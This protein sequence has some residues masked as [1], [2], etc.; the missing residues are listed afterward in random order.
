[1]HRL[2]I[3]VIG[4]FI[5]CTIDPETTSRFDYPPS[6]TA[7]ADT[8]VSINDTVRLHASGS[9]RNG[10]IAEYEWSFDGGKQWTSMH[11]E[12]I[13]KGMGSA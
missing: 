5:L 13:E 8:V 7:M 3:L 1:M 2:L 9:A 6:I 12:L 10:Y 11:Q 4:F